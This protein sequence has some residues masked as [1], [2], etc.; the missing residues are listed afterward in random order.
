M[1]LL[2]GKENLKLNLPVGTSRVEL[3]LKEVPALADPE[4][5]IIRALRN[6]I[7]SKPLQEVVKPGETV[8]L[9]VNDSTRVAR[10]EI[11]LPHIVAELKQ[12]GIRPVDIFVVFTNGTHRPLNH[13]EM[14]SL[15]G[16]EISAEI[17]MY[18]HD[19]NAND[20]VYYGKTSRGTPVS[21]NVRVAQAHRL[22]LTGSIVY[23]F[24]AGFGGGRKALVPGVAGVDT[25]NANHSLMLDQSAQSGVLQGNPVHED[26]LEAAR[27][28]GGDFLFNVVL[29]ENKQ[30]LG[31]FAGDMVEA[32]EAGCQMVRQVYG[33]SLDE[34]ADVVIAS[35]GGHPKDINLYQAQKSLDNAARAVKEGGRLI[36]LACCPEGTGSATYED[37]ALRYNSLAEIEKALQSS[38]Q[39]GGHKAYAVAKVLAHCSVYLVSQLPPDKARRLGFIPA[40][41]LDEAVK[42]VFSDSFDATKTCIIPQ[43]ALTVPL[44]S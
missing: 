10:S 22:I 7:N 14:T 44:L 16:P 29:N 35:C 12:A 31:V 38:F 3:G 36:L 40:T 4:A 37:W 41:S 23:H 20:L 21:I 26:L 13:D 43:G 42:T 28:V 2:Y 18:N 17:A 25:V 24:F 15:V 9:L 39:L 30:I 11:F 34:L 1:N 32:H 27:L 6:P 8:C 33:V 5:E 19:C